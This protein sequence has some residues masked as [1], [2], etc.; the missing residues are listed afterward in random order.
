MQFNLIKE[1]H[2]GVNQAGKETQTRSLRE[3]YH[4]TQNTSVSRQ[5]SS[6]FLIMK[7]VLIS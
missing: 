6:L 7:M 4:L 5:S 1:D 3:W 2:F